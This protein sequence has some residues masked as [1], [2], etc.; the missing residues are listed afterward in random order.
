MFAEQGGPAALDGLHDLMLRLGD[1][2]AAT[3]EEVA[4]VGA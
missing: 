4:G 1:T 2:G 3:F